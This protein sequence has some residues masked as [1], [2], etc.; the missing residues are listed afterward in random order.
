M[1][2]INKNKSLYFDINKLEKGHDQ[3]NI[4]NLSPL[5]DDIQTHRPLIYEHCL[6]QL[7]YT[8]N[9]FHYQVVRFWTSIQHD[10]LCLD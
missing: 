6:N 2:S 3:R 4:S 10:I 1:G 8:C 7:T 9:Q 5:S